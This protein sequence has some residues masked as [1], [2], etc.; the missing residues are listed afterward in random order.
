MDD[1]LNFP[2]QFMGNKCILLSRVPTCAEHDMCQHF[3]MTSHNEW[4]PD[5]V[6]IHVLRKISQLSKTENRY[7]YQSKPDTV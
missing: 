2:V 7:I 4:N 5:S 6:N 3:D 1:E